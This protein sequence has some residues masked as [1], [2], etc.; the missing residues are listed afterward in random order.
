MPR[1]R[2]LKRAANCLAAVAV[3]SVAVFLSGSKCVEP[4][5]PLFARNRVCDPQTVDDTLGAWLATV[6]CLA[7]ILYNSFDRDVAWVCQHAALASSLVATFA[8][9]CGGSSPSLLVVNEVAFFIITAGW[10]SVLFGLVNISAAVVRVPLG[11]SCAHCWRESLAVVV[12]VIVVALT[13]L[14]RV[15]VMT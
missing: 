5:E 11:P 14:D 2:V 9:P 1:D 15:L 10:N 8:T 6:A 4:W 12:T 13:L 7:V 3:L